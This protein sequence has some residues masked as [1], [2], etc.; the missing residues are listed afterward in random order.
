MYSHISSAGY[1][2]DEQAVRAAA[3]PTWDLIDDHIRTATARSTDA[4]KR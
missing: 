4:P 1:S 3:A 2:F